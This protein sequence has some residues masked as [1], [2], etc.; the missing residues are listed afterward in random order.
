ME[1][2]GPCDS[3]EPVEPSLHCETIERMVE[4]EACRLLVTRKI[5]QEPT[6]SGVLVPLERGLTCKVVAAVLWES[7]VVARQK[8]CR[9]KNLEQQA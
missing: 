6:T 8:N 9:R 7:N 5:L 1:H 3:V 2:E 4:A